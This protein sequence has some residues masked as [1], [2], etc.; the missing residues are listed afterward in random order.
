MPCKK[1]NCPLGGDESHFDN[2]AEAQAY[3]DKI[4]KE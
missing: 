2:E 3:V 4:N 1:R